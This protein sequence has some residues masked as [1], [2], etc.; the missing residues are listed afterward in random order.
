[1]QKMVQ[2]LQNEDKYLY[3]DPMGPIST[4]LILYHTT[5]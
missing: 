5:Y 2:D 1:M 4:A 3:E